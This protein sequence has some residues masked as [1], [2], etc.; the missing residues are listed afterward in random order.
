VTARPVVVISHPVHVGNKS[1]RESGTFPAQ[2]QV[3]H[4]EAQP[5]PERPKSDPNAPRVTETSSVFGSDLI[6]ERSLDEV[7]L[8]Y[9]AE[10]GEGSE[11]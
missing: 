6:S 10:D 11:E 7:I 8:A 1:V 3:P 4:P 2:Q 5:Q 9:L